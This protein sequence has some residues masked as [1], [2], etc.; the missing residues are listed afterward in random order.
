MWVIQRDPQGNP[1]T[2]YYNVMNG[3]FIK[4]NENE[5]RY[6]FGQFDITNKVYRFL[7]C[8]LFID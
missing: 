5:W 3:Q 4:V 8:A 2:N 6:I 7:S 1:F